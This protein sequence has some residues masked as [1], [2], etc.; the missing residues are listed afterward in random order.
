MIFNAQTL[1]LSSGVSVLRWIKE[2]DRPESAKIC[3]KGIN[4]ASIPTR[5][6]AAGSNKRANATPM[7][8]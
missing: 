3:A 1:V 6:K 5:P 7:S 8:A 2:A 4:S